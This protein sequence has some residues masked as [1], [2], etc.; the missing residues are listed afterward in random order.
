MIYFR[1]I[2]NHPNGNT[3]IGDWQRDVPFVVEQMC[4]IWI[5]RRINFTVEFK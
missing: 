5:E 1:I 3:I 2:A 4:K